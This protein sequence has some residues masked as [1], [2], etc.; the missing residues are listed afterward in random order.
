MDLPNETI[1]LVL[2]NLDAPSAVCLALTCHRF[3]QCVLHTTKCDKLDDICPKDYN[4]QS[5]KVLQLY[6]ILPLPHKIPHYRNP[7]KYSDYA[8]SFKVSQ[9]RF[10]PA[11]VQLMLCLR[12]WMAPKYVFCF[13]SEST[14]YVRN[15]RGVHKCGACQSE[16]RYLAEHE[17]HVYVERVFK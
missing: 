17:L 9:E 16:R 7:F 3:Y 11:Y 10:N 14:G 1:D 4:K 15:K 8:R 13:A 5:P 12:Q 6:G 2:A